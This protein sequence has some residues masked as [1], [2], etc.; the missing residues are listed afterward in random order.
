MQLDVS[1]LS[2]PV[3]AAA[4]ACALSALGLLFGMADMLAHPKAYTTRSARVAVVLA[5]TFWWLTV[6]M[7]WIAARQRAR[8]KEL[9]ADLVDKLVNETN[10]VD[11][12][13]GTVEKKVAIDLGLADHIDDDDEDEARAIERWDPKNWGG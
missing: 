4:L 8:R 11:R 6:P 10:L 12:V 1:S 3:A 7:A 5:A 9:L 2:W 13:R